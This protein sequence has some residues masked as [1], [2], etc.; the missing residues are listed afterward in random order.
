[1]TTIGQDLEYQKSLLA[2][3]K[4]LQ[5]ENRELKI[6]TER[7]DTELSMALDAVKR[8]SVAKSRFLANMSHEIRTPMNTIIGLSE[9]ALENTH[10]PPDTLDGL[11]R[12][13]NASKLLLSVV[14]DILDLAKLETGKLEL[15][16]KAYDTA[17]LINDVAQF[18][19]LRMGD[20]PLD[21]IIDVGENIPAML[22]GDD[23]R[24]KQ[25][26]N[27][28]LSNAI[29]YTQAG[30]VTLKVASLEEK[31]HTS[32]IF[33]IIDTG[34]GMTNEQIKSLQG[35]GNMSYGDTNRSADGAGLGMNIVNNLIQAMKGMLSVRSLPGEGTTLVVYLPQ[36]PLEDCQDTITKEQIENLRKLNFYSSV[37][38]KTIER[39][40]MPY[41]RVLIVDDMQTNLFVAQGLMKPYGLT[42]ETAMSGFECV[43]K[44]KAGNTYDVIFMDHMM[45]EMDGMQT[46]A[47]L[48]KLGYTAPVVALT[49]NNIVG[50]AEEFLANG[51]DDFMPKPIDIETLNHVLNKHIRDKQTPQV[52]AAAREQKAVLDAQIH[53][54]ATEASVTP[55]VSDPLAALRAIPY[56]DVRTALDAMSGMPDL[57]LDTVK[58]TLR[59]LPE[60]VGKMDDYVNNDLKGF[61]I[62]VH[63]LKS[64]LRNMGAMEL[65]NRADQLETASKA[66]DQAYCQAHYP[67]FRKDLIQLEVHIQAATLGD[68]AGEKA[69]AD[70]STLAPVIETAKAA[71]EAFDRDVAL[72]ALT[73]S[74]G[75][76]YTDVVDALL[77]DIVFAL[78]AFD[79]LGAVEKLT[80][81]QEVI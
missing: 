25:I 57:Y 28:I 37:G 76:T 44:I 49:A 51:F 67:D 23:L 59:L 58:L 21:M 68:E 1:M 79:C 81:L 77:Q 24:I 11:G 45:P 38:R 35:A 32:L 2:I 36:H 41:G 80:S 64:A 6:K 71:A 20:K 4:N 29:K 12:I 43:D 13:H 72:E 47:E 75:Y 52:L 19:T 65:G 33:T 63:G 74:V 39:D 9:L 17:G 60:R 78:E 70:P 30:S 42:I 66:G 7:L 40:H 5:T 54:E 18:N 31:E 3:I 16:P 22:Y 61:S 55:V 50:Q 56:L 34:Q 10:N 46:T 53:S 48:R 73:A 27:N 62:E 15:L 8:T 26:L 14:T 69:T